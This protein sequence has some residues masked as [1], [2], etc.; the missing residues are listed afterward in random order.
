MPHEN[1]NILFV[2]VLVTV[3][4]MATASVRGREK[5]GQEGDQ[6]DQPLIT[7]T[8]D[9]DKHSVTCYK[10]GGRALVDGCHLPAWLGQIYD[11]LFDIN[12]GVR[13]YKLH[14]ETRD[15]ETLYSTPAKILVIPS[16]PGSEV[17]AFAPSNQQP[18]WKVE[19]KRFKE[20]KRFMRKRKV[21]WQ[22]RRFNQGAVLSFIGSF[23]TATVVKAL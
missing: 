9:K 17:T 21:E 15:K 13:P 11:I 16:D 23:E 2:T 12:M 5:G 4:M 18:L 19:S 22:E 14:L 1:S 6:D 7:D 10:A 3:P 8:E 20:V